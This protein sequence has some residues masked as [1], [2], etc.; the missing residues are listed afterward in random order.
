MF[1]N[2]NNV[3]KAQELCWLMKKEYYSPNI[4][5]I[6]YL[7]AFNIYLIKN[8]NFN[9]LKT[10]KLAIFKAKVTGNPTPVVTWR[11]AKGEMNDP[12]K[13]QS[14]Y[15]STTDEHTLE[16]YAQAFSLTFKLLLNI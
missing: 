2:T 10:G 12:Q 9:F 7:K 15:D 14:K 8:S 3:V 11:R 4:F 16:V 1:D 5:H 6:L 13:F